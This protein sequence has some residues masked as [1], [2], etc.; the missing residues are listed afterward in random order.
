MPL[1]DL[2]P[3]DGGQADENTRGRLLLHGAY[4]R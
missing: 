1:P 2:T 3:I 4:A